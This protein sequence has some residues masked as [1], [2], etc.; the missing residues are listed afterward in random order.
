MLAF[1]EMFY[2]N[3]IDN[4]NLERMTQCIINIS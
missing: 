1:K 3:S 2:Y 4:N